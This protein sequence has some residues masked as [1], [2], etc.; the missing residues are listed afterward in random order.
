MAETRSERKK[1]AAKVSVSKKTR[2]VQ[3]PLTP[4]SRR[5]QA[6]SPDLEAATRSSVVAKRWL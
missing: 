5:S 3:V 2:H 1:P 4:S 6:P